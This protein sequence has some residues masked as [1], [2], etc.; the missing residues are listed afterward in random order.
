LAALRA[1]V[2]A[3]RLELPEGVAAPGL[4]AD[5]G[6]AGAA[7]IALLGRGPPD[8]E[9]GTAGCW[10]AVVDLSASV[11]NTVADR[12]A[13]VVAFGPGRF[14]GSNRALYTRMSAPNSAVCGQALAISTWHRN[15]VF[16][17]AT[18]RPTRPVEGGAKRAVVGPGGGKAYPRI[19]PVAIVL[20]LSHDG[21]HC[22]LTRPRRLAREVFTCVAGFVEQGETVEEA[23][24]REAREEA[25]VTLAHVTLSASQPWPLGRGGSYELMLG[26][27]ATAV[28]GPA[29]ALP[30]LAC[31]DL[32]EYEGD[33]DLRWF[34][35][36]DAR[37]SPRRRP[38]PAPL[39]PPP[40]LAPPS[41]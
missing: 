6:A 13:L 14:L 11:G 25:G 21:S 29:G 23:A 22:L 1:G 32:A 37:L 18:G 16:C 41:S 2:P 24:R 3:L 36:A 19:D 27:L 12:D 35:K 17:G 39:P 9:N 28:P 31:G 30:A 38:P 7:H 26:C 10:H 5:P 8:G 15:N 34:S 40:P 4:A 20:I 33:Q